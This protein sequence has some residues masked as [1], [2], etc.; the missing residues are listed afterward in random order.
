MESR[1]KRRRSQLYKWGLYFLLLL[2]CTV[3]QTLP[4]FLQ[5]GQAKPV[6]LL[7]LA[8]A[9]AVCEDEFS[10][11]LFGAVCGLM[12][13]YT[14]GRTAGLLAL[15]LMALSFGI[16]VAS[17]LYLK[18]TQTNFALVT[19]G[20]L[21]LVLS[22]DQLCP[23]HGGGS[24]AGAVQRLF[25]LLRHAGLQQYA[26]AVHLLCAADRAAECRAGDPVLSGGELDQHNL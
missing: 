9:V 23:R 22:R 25:V 17:Q 10:G 14:A 21:W 4:G 7:S 18:L 1:R 26:G 2:A 8:L 16:S 15:T 13:D 19:A 20:A 12:W 5:F 6:F 11:A 3:L 24:L